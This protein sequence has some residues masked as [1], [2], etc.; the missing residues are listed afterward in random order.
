M[1]WRKYCSQYR[2]IKLSDTLLR[3]YGYKHHSIT[4][5]LS[6]FLDRDYIRSKSGHTIVFIEIDK[7]DYEVRD[8][9]GYN[10]LW[11]YS[12]DTYNWTLLKGKRSINKTITG[13]P[14]E[15]A[16]YIADWYDKEAK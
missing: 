1:A 4:P 5:N 15:I 9:K 8:S 13:S 11:A 12:K 14:I 6:L 10:G 3:P 2:G 16:R 7:D